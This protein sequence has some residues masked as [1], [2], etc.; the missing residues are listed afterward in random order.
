MKKRK[1]E[2]NPYP[3]V[4]N[5]VSLPCAIFPTAIYQPCGLKER[6]HVLPQLDWNQPAPRCPSP[7]KHLTHLSPPPPHP[8]ISLP[9]QVGNTEK[10][11]FA[12]SRLWWWWHGGGLRKLVD[13]KFVWS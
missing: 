9:A 12:A 1:E 4:Q 10:R 5:C 7:S 11:P 13:L 8:K 2:K 6:L 3:L